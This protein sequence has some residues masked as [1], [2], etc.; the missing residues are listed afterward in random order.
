MISY[1]ELMTIFIGLFYNNKRDFL[2]KSDYI[3]GIL[4]EF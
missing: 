2:Q 3:S 1:K 4:K